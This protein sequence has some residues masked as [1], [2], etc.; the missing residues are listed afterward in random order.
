M[1]ELPDVE[2][3]RHTLASCARGR[4]VERVEVADPGV[5]HGVTPQRLNRDL[6][7][8]RFAEPRRHGKWLIAP[9]DGPTVL[10][11]FGMTGRLVCG[12]ATDPPGRFERVALALDDGHRLGY[13]DQR[14][15]RGIWL[16]ATDADTDRILGEQGPDALT[17]SRADFD[18]RLEGRRGGIKSTLT[19]QSVVAG[20]GNLLSDEILWRARIHPRRP[21]SALTADE[22]RRL[23]TAMREVLRTSVRAEE[24][25]ARPSWLTGHRDDPDPHCPRCGHPLRRTRIAGRTSVWCPH[26]Q[27][28]AS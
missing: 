8:R 19:D 23:H 25:P 4:R 18:K 16:A 9:T 7:G 20:L 3:F 13:E 12:A 28:E 26:C 24:I 10:L 27:P 15:L 22:R 2:G 11:H 5:L 14:K 1:P 6:K 17:L 21:T